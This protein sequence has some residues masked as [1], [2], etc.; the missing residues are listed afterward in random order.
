[1]SLL[2]ALRES[3]ASRTIARAAR[4]ADDAQSEHVR[5]DATKFLGALDGVAPVARHEI[6]HK[7]SGAA[8]GLVINLVAAH[9]QPSMIDVSP[10]PAK[11]AGAGDGLPVRVPHPSERKGEP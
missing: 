7:H 1:V 4:L 2:G 3:E 8:P 11:I 6:A 9:P 5:L 10:R